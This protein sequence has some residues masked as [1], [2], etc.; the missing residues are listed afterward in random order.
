MDKCTVGDL[1]KHLGQFDPDMTV[2]F[3]GENGAW[4]ISSQE[5]ED[6]VFETNDLDY[7]NDEPVEDEDFNILLIV[8]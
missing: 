1:M 4:T 3:A 2:A 8:A 6:V 7:L 5:L